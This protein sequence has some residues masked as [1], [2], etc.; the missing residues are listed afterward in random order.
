MPPAVAL[1]EQFRRFADGAERDGAVTYA[2]ICRGVADRADVL[3][4]VLQAP[5]SQQRPNI[6]LAAV[7]YLLLRGAAHALALHYDTVRQVRGVDLDGEQLATSVDREDV[8][9]LFTDFCRTFRSDLGDLCSTRRTQTNEVGRCSALLPALSFVSAGIPHRSIA[10]LDLG[11]SAGLNLFFDRY[12]Y[13]YREQASGATRRGGDVASSVNLECVVRQPLGALPSLDVPEV[14]ARAGLDM[15]PVDATS[16]EGAQWLLA[17]L[18]PDNLARFVRLREALHIARASFITTTTAPVPP[19]HHGDIVEDLARVAATMADDAP[20]VVFHSWVAAY[21]TPERQEE[22]VAAVQDLARGRPL[23]YLYAEA[24]N[25]TPRLPTPPSPSTSPNASA[26]TA[27]VHIDFTTPAS[28]R[29][30]AVRLADM[31]PH[32]RWLHWWAS[33]PVAT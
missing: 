30:D 23:H 24:P 6:I 8:V 28:R 31:H 25:E 13:T 21:L 27:L 18:W 3:D 32:G 22:L 1:P 9:A 2:A 33:P 17:C 11:T 15:D 10:F 7:H 20:L 26:R 5:E 16:D 19:I 29:P 14:L 4:L 12:A